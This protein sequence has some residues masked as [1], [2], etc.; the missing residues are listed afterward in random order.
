MK[1]PNVIDEPDTSD[2]SYTKRFFILV[3]GLIAVLGL[4]I[5]GFFFITSLGSDEN[6]GIKADIDISQ[7]EQD[8]I[9]NDINEFMDQ[10]GNFGLE[11]EKISGDNIMDVK[12]ILLA[13]DPN[14]S[15]FFKTRDSS[16]LYLRDTYMLANSPA[17]IPNRSVESWD[18]SYE[19]D[20]LSTYQL[21]DKEVKTPAKGY[22]II[23]NNQELTAAK[24]EVKFDSKITKRAMTVTDSGSRG[25]FN[26][27]EK[28]FNDNTATITVVKTPE[29]PW[30]IYSIE[31]LNTPI[32]LATWA[33]PDE[34]SYYSFQE[35][36]T[37][38]GEIESKI[39]T[40]GETDV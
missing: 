7:E 16:Y 32:L 10:A 13:Q 4:I 2:S 37:V 25:V 40:I 35:D 21:I 24:V 1:L 8:R 3:G 23:V 36:F 31:D 19:K 22:R 29:G 6:D 30:K 17:Y 20:V 26:I 39:D 34:T 38:T 14:Q 33:S 28:D 15:N 9:T 5:G 11:S 12:N 27:M 18:T